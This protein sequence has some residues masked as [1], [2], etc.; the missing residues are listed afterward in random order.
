MLPSIETIIQG[1]VD[2]L[3]AASLVSVV[4]S[5]EGGKSA[6]ARVPER[7]QSY[8]IVGHERSDAKRLG[9]G[10]VVGRAIHSRTRKIVLDVWYPW[11]H[12]LGSAAN[13]RDLLDA[14][15]LALQTRQQLGVCARMLTLP[16]I[17]FNRVEAYTSTT[18][19]DTPVYCHHG[20]IVFTVQ[21]H[22]EVT[23]S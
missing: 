22:T 7:E 20:R 10:G 9:V 1:A 8:C 15:V 4:D 19:G 23:G 14:I 21:G 2:T 18:Q 5:Q 11:S 3:E 16:A 6:W 12:S 13:Y 17:E